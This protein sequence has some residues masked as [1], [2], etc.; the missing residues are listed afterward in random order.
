MKTPNAQTNGGTARGTLEKFPLGQ[1]VR[2]DPKQISYVLR[3]CLSLIHIGIY[4][5]DLN[6]HIDLF[7]AP[8]NNGQGQGEAQVIMGRRQPEESLWLV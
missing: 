2:W 6:V 4:K 7:H 3:L 5:N 8:K 1:V